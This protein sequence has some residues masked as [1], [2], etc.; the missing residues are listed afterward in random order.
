ME[1]SFSTKSDGAH[2]LLTVGGEIDI[3][4]APQLRT[5]LVELVGGG[6]RWLT[7]DLSPVGFI[8]STGL[9]VLVGARRRLVEAGG[10]LSLVVPQEPLRA[11]F[12]ATGLGE[13]FPIFESI[14]DVREF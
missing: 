7:I 14:D 8:D 6:C 4:T 13:I 10:E 5:E 11:L 12:T 1:L 9:G 2:T 3:A